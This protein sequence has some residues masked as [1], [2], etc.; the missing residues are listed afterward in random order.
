MHEARTSLRSLLWQWILCFG[1]FAGMLLLTHGRP[2]P[3]AMGICFVIGFIVIA[4]A[5]W[6]GL[7]RIKKFLFLMKM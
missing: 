7:E 3:I 1:I 5:E 6:F 2:S 4:L